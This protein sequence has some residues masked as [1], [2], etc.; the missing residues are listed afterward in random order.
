MRAPLQHGALFLAALWMLA[1]QSGCTSTG[2]GLLGFGPHRLLKTAQQVANQAA[3][4]MPLPRELAKQ[5]LP[6]Y[7]VEPGDILL[8]ETADYESN[9]RL[10]GDQRVQPDGIIDL[11]QYGTVLAAGRTVEEIED[12]VSAQIN[13]GRSTPVDIQ[14]RLVE[15]LGNVYYVLGEVNSPGAY[16][17]I[18]RETVL[19]AIVAAGDLTDRAN[20]HKIILSRPSDPYDCR[21]ALPICY[22]HIVQL[23]DTS[24]NYQIRPGDRIF[25]A[26]LSLLEEACQL[27]C[28]AHL[29]RC[30][31]CADP[32]VACVDSGGEGTVVAG[33]PD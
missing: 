30:P 4:P 14:V 2:G 22:R 15:P 17:T 21:T 11:G 1:A 24:T 5:V 20:R 27:L 33:P 3:H 6:E 28:P 18:G 31:R 19:D 26:S 32:H 13:R 12:D 25:V 10:P 7:Q 23:G 9:I 16:P 8:V 29:E